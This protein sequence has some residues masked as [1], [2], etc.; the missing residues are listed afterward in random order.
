LNSLQNETHVIRRGSKR[1]NIPLSSM[2]QFYPKQQQQQEKQLEDRLEEDYKS[3][4][5]A[6][7]TT[8]T[9][10][11]V[12][13][14]MIPLF[15][16][17]AEQ[18]PRQFYA[19]TL[20]KIQ[21]TAGMRLLTY[22]QQ[23]WIY[24]HL[25]QGLVVHHRTD[26]DTSS[27]SPSFVF[28]LFQRSDIATLS[29][30]LEGFYGVVAANYLQGNIDPFLN[31]K[32]Q[33]EVEMEDMALTQLYTT[34]SSSSYPLVGALDMGGSSTQIVYFSPSTESIL[35]TSTTSTT[36]HGTSI[37]TT[38]PRTSINHRTCFEFPS[39]IHDKT[40][41]THSYDMN[42]IMHHSN[43]NDTCFL[44]DTNTTYPHDDNNNSKKMKP[45]DF[46]SIS[47]L[48]FGVDQ[49]RQR[50]YD[51]WVQ[52]ST[53]F[54]FISKAKT[55]GEEDDDNDNEMMAV[56]YNPCHFQGYTTT[57]K[58]YTMIGIGNASLCALEIN[59]LIPHYPSQPLEANNNEGVDDDSTSPLIMHD[60]TSTSSSSLYTTT[61]RMV[62]GVQYPPTLQGKF[63]AMS[64]FFFTLDCL[65]ELSTHEP[66]KET[67]PTPTIQDLAIA[68]ESLCSRQWYGDLEV[69]QHEAHL[70]TRAE[71]LPERCF[72]SVYMVTLLRDGY[73]FPMESQDITFTYLVGGSE[74]EWSLGMAL[75]LFAQE[76]HFLAVTELEDMVEH[77]DSLLSTWNRSMT[78]ET[79]G[80][81]YKNETTTKLL[82]QFLSDI[83]AHLPH[84]VS[85]M[86]Y[87]EIA[88][89]R[90]HFLIL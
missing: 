9:A 11:L 17:A 68:L 30:N 50:L 78:G 16:Y 54:R 83:I 24:D 76:N 75:S 47:H 42:D 29:G 39:A 10:R 80:T 8:T 38:E 15:E 18:I 70:Y 82:S 33:L 58:G 56:L 31:V 79:K 88:T 62:G 7:T 12:A 63:I 19:N 4:T 5:T 71:I 1:V 34:S 74:V 45:Q 87:Q 81:E 25:Y 77:S 73:G 48:S 2:I 86:S 51:S 37:I 20:V 28:T 26:N 67:W 59:R 72:E 65:R 85:A 90:G 69:I 61:L 52:D 21:A 55:P 36:R 27:S 6:A 14:H 60:D 89:G 66:L 35:D 40:N 53:R 64:L 3:N 43:K 22:E 23:I 49:F 57:Y 46:V 84:W 41:R 32:Q 44:Q 13:Q